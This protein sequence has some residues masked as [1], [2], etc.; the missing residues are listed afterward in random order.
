MYQV[1]IASHIQGGHDVTCM[2]VRASLSPFTPLLAM[3]P[4]SRNTRKLT[5]QKATRSLAGVYQAGSVLDISS[6]DV[7]L[8]VPTGNR[9]SI[10]QDAAFSMQLQ[11]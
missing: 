4:L 3:M 2:P 6:E 9:V 10:S 7:A 11:V 8:L 5:M 1:C